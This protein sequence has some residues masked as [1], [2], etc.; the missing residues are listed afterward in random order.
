MVDIKVEFFNFS[1]VKI[2]CE[3]SILFDLKDYFSFFADGYNFHPKFKYGTWDGKIHLL[4]NNGL[5]PIGLYPYIRKFAKNMGYS[6]LVDDAVSE[7]EDVTREEFDTWVDGMKYYSG[8]NEIKPYWYQRD[9]VYEAISK[10]RAL[11]VLPTSAGKSLIQA[12]LCKYYTEAYDGKVLILVPTTSL[13][14]QMKSD[15][16]DYRLFKDEDVLEI[17]SGTKRDDRKARIYVSTWQTAIKQPPEWFEQFGMLLNDECHKATGR[18]ISTI[19]KG[20]TN[21]IFKIGLSGTLKDGKANVMQY[22]GLFGQQFKPTDTKRLMDEGQA[23][24]LKI[25]AIVLNY[26]DEVKLKMKELSYADEVKV[27]NGYRKRNSVVCNLACKVSKQKNENIFVMFKYKEHGKSLYEEI[28]KTHGEKT[29]LVSGDNST[30]DRD[31]L[32]RALED[33]DGSIVVASYGVFSTG[34]SIK[35]LHHVFF[36]HGVK[37]KITVLQ[38]IGRILRNHSSKEVATLWDFIDDAGIRFKK[39]PKKY[40]HKNYLLKHAIER[41]E[42]YA[43]ESFDYSLKTINL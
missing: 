29:Y 18:S 15:F 37:D 7:K 13:T 31:I 10:H 14:V 3:S 22:E 21:C 9:S 28:K 36:A 1:Y 26:P 12:L 6:L 30:K 11:L 5:L 24:K 16:L 42:R 43:A 20:L 41:I 25:N 34:I 33:Q 8:K 39:D 19:I 23:T 38:S 17:R 35:N 4:E 40:K 2:V 32:K 27:V